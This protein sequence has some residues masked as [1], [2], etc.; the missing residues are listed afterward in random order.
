MGTQDLQA[1]LKDLFE[2]WQELKS[3]VVHQKYEI[4]RG[5]RTVELEADVVTYVEKNVRG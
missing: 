2:G 3:T 5:E 4:P 1:Q